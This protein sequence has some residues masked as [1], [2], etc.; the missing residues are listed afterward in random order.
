MPAFAW[1]GVRANG[2]GAIGGGAAG[3][4]TGGVA[5][6]AVVGASVAAAARVVERVKRQGCPLR[7]PVLVDIVCL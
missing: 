6:A 4:A 7:P 5:G 3:A 2:G 1:A